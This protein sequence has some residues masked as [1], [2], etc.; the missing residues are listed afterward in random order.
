MA[1]FRERADIAARGFVY[2]AK[3]DEV[4]TGG[5]GGGNATRFRGWDNF[6]RSACGGENGSAD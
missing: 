6:R 3:I 4:R 5:R 1:G 2:A